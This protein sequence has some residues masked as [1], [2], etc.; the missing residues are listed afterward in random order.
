[1]FVFFISRRIYISPF[2]VTIAYDVACSHRG[3][4]SGQRSTGRV[5]SVLPCRL[6][7]GTQ[8][9]VSAQRVFTFTQSH[10][11]ALLFRFTCLLVAAVNA[12][13]LIFLESMLV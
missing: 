11:R 10:L 2:I 1:M 8:A 3:T 4:W 12:S 6:V 5:G 13:P 9:A 7:G